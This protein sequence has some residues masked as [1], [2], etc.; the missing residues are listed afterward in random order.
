MG[1]KARIAKDILPIM[2]DDIG[3]NWF[4]DLFCGGGNLIQF[5]TCKKKF[6][7][8]INPYTIAFLKTLQVKGTDWLPKTV[9]EFN[10]ENYMYMKSHKDAF[11]Q[12]VLGHVGYNLSYGGKWFGGFRADKVGKRDYVAE[13]YRG[14]YKQAELIKDVKFACCSYDKVKIPPNAV[15]Y[16]DI[17]YKGTTKYEAVDDFDHKAFYDWCRA[18]TRK[19]IKVYVSEYNMPE[20]FKCVWQKDIRVQTKKDDNSTKATEKLFLCNL[21]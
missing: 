12:A 8:D 5:A 9:Q 11:S 7:S 4:M 17:P 20:D 10:R 2:L 3:D 15:V 14:A 16:C 1:S 19:G 18:R 6:A 21:T 13:A